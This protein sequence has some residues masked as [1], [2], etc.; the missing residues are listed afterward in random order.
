MAHIVRTPTEIVLAAMDEFVN[1]SAL[2]MRVRRD[3]DSKFGKEGNKVGDTINLRRPQR[4]ESKNQRELNLQD[5]YQ[6]TVPVRLNQNPNIGLEIDEIQQLLSI[7]R[8]REDIIG[9]QAS[10][11]GNDVDFFLT[12][13]YKQIWNSAGT[14]G[15]AISSLSPFMRAKRLMHDNGCPPDLQRSMVYSPGMEEAIVPALVALQNPQGAISEQYSEGEMRKASGMMWFMS[16]NIRTHTVG[17]L[18]GTP[19]V[20][21]ANQVAT[22]NAATGEWE[23][24]IITDGWTAAAARRLNDGD[25]I[26]FTGVHRVNPLNRQSTGLLQDFVVRGDVDS[27]AGGAATF[28]ISPPIITEGALQTVDSAPADDAPIL[29]YGLDATAQADIAGIETPVALAF[30]KSAIALAMGSLSMPPNKKGA[31]IADPD[32]GVAMRWV[33]D[34]EIRS[35]LDLSRL[36]AL[37]GGGM[38]RPEWC[39]RI[40]GAN[41]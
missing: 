20:N 36:E 1:R 16:Q 9:P 32:M 13:F 31:S 38:L 37:F 29:V 2:T 39:V 34:W 30:H 15:T 26:Q 5:I 24:S 33:R 3:F 17:P 7:E 4:F 19:L 18:G 35:G 21:G 25:V 11:I 23:Q 28:T 10:Q 41:S 12:G 40:H 27:S 8:L 14:P 22:F 6:S